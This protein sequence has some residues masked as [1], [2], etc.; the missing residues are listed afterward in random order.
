MGA[1]NLMKK[2]KEDPTGLFIPSGLFIGL[3]IGFIYHEIVSGF[4]IGLGVG[5]LFMSIAKVITK[6]GDA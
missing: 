1:E 2:V 3:G 4:L 5:F 6:S